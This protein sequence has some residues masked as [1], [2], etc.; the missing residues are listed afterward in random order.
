MKHI[1]LMFRTMVAELQQRTFDARWSAYFPP[2]GR[3]VSVK[4]DSRSY[5]YFD[6]PDGKGGQKLRYVDPADDNEITIRSAQS[7]SNVMRPILVSGC[8]WL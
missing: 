6:Q 8:L 3:F 4:V 2:T 5:W 1:D 7:R